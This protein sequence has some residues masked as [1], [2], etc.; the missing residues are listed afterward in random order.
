MHQTEFKSTQGLRKIPQVVV[1][2]TSDNHGNE[3]EAEGSMSLVI[4]RHHGLMLL[5][6]RVRVK[7]K[8]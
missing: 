7:G 1:G 6:N 4:R 2:P 5:L 8:N 3:L